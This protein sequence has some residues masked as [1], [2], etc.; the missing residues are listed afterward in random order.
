M[1]LIRKRTARAPR[2]SCWLLVTG[3]LR[4][5]AWTTL[6]KPGAQGENPQT[7]SN[8]EPGTRR[9]S[10]SAP[11]RGAP[12]ERWC[13]AAFAQVGDRTAL[14]SSALRG[15]DHHERALALCVPRDGHDDGLSEL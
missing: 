2:V 15:Q 8:R 12:G 6:G 11:G 14:S 10:A 5:P 7:T 3:C 9:A 13:A 4:F 1:E